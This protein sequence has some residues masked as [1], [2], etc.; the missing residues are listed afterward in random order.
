LAI[1]SDQLNAQAMSH[2]VSSIAVDR[3]TWGVAA[4]INPVTM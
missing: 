4:R 1:P 3:Q 2:G